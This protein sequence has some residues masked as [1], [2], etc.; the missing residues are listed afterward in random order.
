MFNI[1]YTSCGS[2]TN[3]KIPMDLQPHGECVQFGRL[4]M[5]MRNMNWK[6]KS[7]FIYCNLAI[8]RSWS[9]VITTCHNVK[10]HFDLS[11]WAHSPENKEHWSRSRR[12]AD[13]QIAWNAFFVAVRFFFFFVHFGH[14]VLLKLWRTQ[15][16]TERKKMNRLNDKIKKIDKEIP[17]SSRIAKIT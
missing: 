7:N 13:L 2:E 5:R 17:T 12:V 14:Q 4:C 9:I 15:A 10:Y 16:T 6:N 1:I 8:F 11:R 3:E